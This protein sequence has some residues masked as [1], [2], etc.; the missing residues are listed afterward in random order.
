MSGNITLNCLNTEY[1]FNSVTLESVLHL[2]KTLTDDSP[3]G[4]MKDYYVLN[5]YNFKNLEVLLEN[6]LLY[7]TLYLLPFA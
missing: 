7:E 3:I 2:R 1:T 6:D 5:L 4:E